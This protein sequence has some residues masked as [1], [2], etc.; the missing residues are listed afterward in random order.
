MGIGQIVLEG[1]DLNFLA[2]YWDRRQDVCE[3]GNELMC[4]IKSREFHN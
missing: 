1:V 3:Y 4:S 2:I